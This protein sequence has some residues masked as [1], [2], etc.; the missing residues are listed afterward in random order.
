MNP[1][2]TPAPA[3]DVSHLP[4][5]A[6]GE[7]SPLW[8][9]NLLAIFIETATVAIMVAS[10]FYTRMNFGA[11]PPPKVDVVPPV[12]DT[13]PDL[14]AATANVVLLLASCLLMYWTDMAARRKDQ[15][16]VVVGLVILFFVACA[17]VTLRAFEFPA[18]KF[19]WNDN[20]YASVVWM[21]LGLHLTYILAGLGEFFIMG[22]WIMT[23][24]LDDKHALD[25]TLAGGYWYWVA[26]TAALNYAVI[27]WSPRLL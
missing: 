18:T 1:D 11:W 19:W 26:A 24:P 13:N 25:V 23:H 14:G 15:G 12:H 8:W 21:M 6:F 2:D 5:S 3:L 22:V 16:R 9:G 4:N 17:A 27:Y 7:R 20:A 10:Y